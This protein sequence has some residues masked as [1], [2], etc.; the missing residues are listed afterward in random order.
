[1]NIE[2]KRS[3]RMSQRTEALIK[4]FGIEDIENIQFLADGFH[5]KVYLHKMNDQK[6][7]VIKIPKNFKAAGIVHSAQQEQK[8][9][10]IVAETFKEHAVPTAVCESEK[11]YAV[12][13]DEIQGKPLQADAIDPASIFYQPELRN[14]LAQIIEANKELLRT[15]G[16]FLDLTGAHALFDELQRPIGK[17]RSRELAN[18]LVEENP[19]TKQKTLRII[20]NDLISMRNGNVFE[21]FKSLVV[22]VANYQAIRRD[23]SMDIRPEKETVRT[24][25]PR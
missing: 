2:Y 23:F 16:Q 24:R 14:Q 10:D 8:N 9:A 1:M 18:I 6:S 15:T 11:G 22:F 5:H 7:Q 17:T 3:T 4:S 12:I 13:M 19:Q 21:R 25:R 20:D